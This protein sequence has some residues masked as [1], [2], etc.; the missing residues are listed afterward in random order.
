MMELVLAV[1]CMLGV[2]FEDTET[3]FKRAVFAACDSVTS[4]VKDVWIQL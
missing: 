4:R 2:R 1:V 3:D